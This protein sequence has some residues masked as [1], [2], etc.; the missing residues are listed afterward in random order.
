MT[1][2]LTNTVAAPHHETRAQL[3]QRGV[4]LRQREPQ[5]CATIG[6]GPDCVVVDEERHDVLRP[7]GRR[8]ERRV[9]AD[10][11]VTSEEHDCGAHRATA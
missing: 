5:D 4:E 3:A 8:R 9:I 7:F 10:P 2:S 11:K 6:A 1:S